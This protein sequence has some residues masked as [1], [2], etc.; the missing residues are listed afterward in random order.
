MLHFG[1]ITRL[2]HLEAKKIQISELNTLEELKD[3]TILR[4]LFQDLYF[5]LFLFSQDL[6]SFVKTKMKEVDSFWDCH[7]HTHFILLYVFQ[8]KFITM[9]LTEFQKNKVSKNQ[10]SKKQVLKKLVFFQKRILSK[11][12]SNLFGV[13]S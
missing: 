11:Y 9:F 8:L 7:T 10:V 2:T 4:R 6:Q 13:D 12:G 5:Y 3:Q 1:S